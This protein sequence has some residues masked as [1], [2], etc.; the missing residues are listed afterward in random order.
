MIIFPEVSDRFGI[1]C[2]ISSHVLSL[3]MVVPLVPNTKLY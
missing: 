2:S 3:D 1:L